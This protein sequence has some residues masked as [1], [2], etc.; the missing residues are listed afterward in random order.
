MVEFNILYTDTDSG[1]NTLHRT[2]YF[3][4]KDLAKLQ[5]EQKTDVN[6]RNNLG[7]TALHMACEKDFGH[8]V[9]LLLTYSCDV[10]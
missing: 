6:S 1:N 3:G 5:I 10:N 2:A 9:E 8:I 4:V 7:R